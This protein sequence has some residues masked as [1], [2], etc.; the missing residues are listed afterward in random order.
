V[1]WDPSHYERFKNER[2]RPFFDLLAL[3]APIPGG[4][5]IDLG[6]GTGELTR[7]LH[8][9]I[10]AAETLGVDSSAEML[11]RSQAFAG[12]GLRF[13]RGDIAAFDGTSSWDLIF[14]NAALHWIDD[15]ATLLARLAG[16]LRAGGQLAVQVPANHDHPSHRTARAVA[17]QEPFR[18]AGG[19]PASP[20][21]AAEA[22]ARLLHQLGFREQVV[23]LEVYGHTLGARDE[24]VEWVTG[25]TLTPLRA[26]LD[27]AGWKQ[28]LDRYRQALLPQ[29]QDSRPYFYT[30]KRILLWGRR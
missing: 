15:H 5:A 10:Q 19:L 22:Y 2:S 21:L 3:V 27:D 20:V 17:D 13:E 6:C 23:R 14:S 1:T 4:R 29:L 28:F 25:T 30:F 8:Q 26:R 7:A 24:V 16:A 18:A 12:G 9:R 11:A